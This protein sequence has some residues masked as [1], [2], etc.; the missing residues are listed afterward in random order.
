MSTL[1]KR[2]ALSIHEHVLRQV[3]VVRNFSH[4]VVSHI[5]CQNLW[6]YFL[7]PK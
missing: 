2:I 5:L 4:Q 3:N 1:R 7:T 6:D